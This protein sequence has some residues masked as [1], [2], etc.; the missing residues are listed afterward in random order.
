[1]DSNSS[2]GIQEYHPYIQ[3][4]GQSNSLSIVGYFLLQM[5]QKHLDTN[6]NNTEIS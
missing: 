2:Q 1:M 6:I 4:Y 3:A 5:Y